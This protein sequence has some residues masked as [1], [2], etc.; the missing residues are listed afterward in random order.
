MASF[1]RH[2]AEPSVVLPLDPVE[3]AVARL[4]LQRLHGTLTGLHE[5]GKLRRDPLT[6]SGIW[7][8]HVAAGSAPGSSDGIIL[9]WSG[10]PWGG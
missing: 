9:P 3:T 7:L 1:H 4:D 6:Q 2:R 5:A 8:I 10:L